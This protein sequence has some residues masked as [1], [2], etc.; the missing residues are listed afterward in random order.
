MIDYFLQ[1][2]VIQPNLLLKET[3]GIALLSQFNAHGV[4]IVLEHVGFFMMRLSM[5]C[6]APVFVGKTKCTAGSS[7]CKSINPR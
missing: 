1:V 7:K 2:S 6:M 5:L 4:F 3:D